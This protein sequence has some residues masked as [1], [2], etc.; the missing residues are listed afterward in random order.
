MI[1]KKIIRKNKIVKMKNSNID[2]ILD[3]QSLNIID[4]LDNSTFLNSVYKLIIKNYLGIND[5]DRTKVLNY[6]YLYN[7]LNISPL[8]YDD[9]YSKIGANEA[10]VAKTLSHKNMTSKVE[11]LLNSEYIVQMIEIA[12]RIVILEN[13]TNKSDNFK[14]ECRFILSCIKNCNMDLSSSLEKLL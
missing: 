6:T 3:N 4:G 13:S 7:F 10:E 12:S 5:V 9:I 8:T 14:K 2:F 1:K 11:A